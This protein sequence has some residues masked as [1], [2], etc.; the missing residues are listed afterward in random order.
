MNT[1]KKKHNTVRTRVQIDA[2]KR[3]VDMLRDA[4]ELVQA[5][6]FKV[7]EARQ[8]RHY[9]VHDFLPGVEIYN[10]SGAPK[11]LLQDLDRAIQRVSTRLALN[12]QKPNKAG[13]INPKAIVNSRISVH[14][15]RYK[16]ACQQE[17][18]ETLQNAFSLIGVFTLLIGAFLAAYHYYGPE[19]F[20]QS[21]NIFPSHW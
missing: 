7:E 9:V 18:D 5:D 11:S 12:R 10:L 6:D 4:L 21:F 15:K 17:R 3:A 14:K 8:L 2:E 1:P 13:I 20:Y 16:Q 19:M